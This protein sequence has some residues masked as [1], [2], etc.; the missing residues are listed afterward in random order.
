MNI[1]ANKFAATSVKFSIETLVEEIKPVNS[2][3]KKEF[4]Y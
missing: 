1:F 3:K 2:K 4:E